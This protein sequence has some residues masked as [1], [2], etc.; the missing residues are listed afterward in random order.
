MTSLEDH[1]GIVDIVLQFGRAF[2]SHDWAALRA[3]LAS[4]LDT[5]YSS[6]RGTPPQ[7]LKSE[8]FVEMRRTALAGLRTQHIS[9]DHA[10][11][12]AGDTATCKC[13]FVIRRWPTDSGD[14]R[15]LHSHGKY[16]FVLQ[17]SSGRWLI[18]GIKQVV[19]YNEGELTL[20]GALR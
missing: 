19:T 17:R 9:T 15:F 2:D 6:F 11:R 5:D 16:D 14:T 10:V 4:D 1:Q 3:C 20:H 12:S 8:E 13:N 7:R 18:S